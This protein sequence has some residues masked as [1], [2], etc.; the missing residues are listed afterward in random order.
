MVD[1]V[2]QLG[3]EVAE[4]VVR[5][6]REVHD[7]VEALEV[8]LDDIAGVLADRR[9]AHAGAEAAA[10]EEVDVEAD[11]LVARLLQKRH[12]DSANVSVVTGYQN[13]HMLAFLSA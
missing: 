11:D 4:G 8:A 1:V 6:R 5:Q 13:L 2:G 3:V 9:D 7:G 12:Q 10:L